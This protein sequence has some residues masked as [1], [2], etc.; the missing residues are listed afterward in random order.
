MYSVVRWVTEL[1]PD[2]LITMEIGRMAN[3]VVD[4]SFNYRARIR[5]AWVE[6]ARFDN[7]HGAPHLHRFWVPDTRLLHFR[8]LAAF[9]SH[10]QNDLI[11][12][13]AKYRRLMERTS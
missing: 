12:N 1:T 4:V 9:A 10:A 8:S 6:V 11:A 5:G 2:D 3:T 7:A 13:W